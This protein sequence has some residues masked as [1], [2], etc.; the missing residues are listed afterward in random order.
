MYKMILQPL[1]HC[2]SMPLK[3]A[4]LSPSPASPKSLTPLEF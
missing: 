2:G 1:L 3:Q 4:Q